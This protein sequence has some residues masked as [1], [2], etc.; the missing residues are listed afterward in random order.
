MAKKVVNQV[1]IKDEELTPTTL[2][3]YSNKGKN[4]IGLIL[5]ILIFLLVVL[6]QLIHT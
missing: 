1:V 4:P 3:V 5:I 6:G 2:G